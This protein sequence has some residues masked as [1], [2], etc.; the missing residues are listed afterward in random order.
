MK[1]CIL[2]SL[3]FGML[4]AATA[5]AFAQ[6]GTTGPLTWELNNGTLTISGEGAMP[7]Y[8]MGI[9]GEPNTPWNPYTYSITT[10][11]ITNGVTSIG[12]LAFCYCSR[13]ISIAIPNSVTS[14]GRATFSGCESL[15][16]IT[17][18]N[19]V[20][21]IGEYP[22]S[23]CE[24]LISINVE[25]GNNSYASEDGVLFNKSKTILIRYPIGKTVETYVI[26]NS[27]TNIEDGA[28]CYCESLTSI[29][30][31]NDVT[32]IGIIAFSHCSSLNSVIVPNSVTTIGEGAFHYCRSLPSIIIP[33]SVISI[34]ERT[35]ASCSRLS[36]ITN[37]N[38]VPVEINSNVFEYVKINECTLEVPM[39]SVSAYQ[40]AEVWKEFNITNVGIE[41]LE[42]DNIKIYP[43]PTYD[44]FTVAFDGVVSIKLHDMLG[45]EILTQTANGNTEINISHLPKGVY[46]VH[47]LSDGK[48]VGNSK[49]VKE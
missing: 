21:T 17:I 22:F 31:P 33:N 37:L 2:R 1:K 46:H 30:I 38:P 19:S 47:V 23:W 34:G 43:N 9:I 12:N 26:P 44:K 20:T 24:S 11:V 3:V 35:F 10:V 6:G 32:N 14:I 5:T 4:F 41:T 45:K 16:S 8:E 27:V 18:P 49:I 25:N 36:L 42:P 48:V 39:T 28:F 15:I 40:N 29:T 13:L 7:D